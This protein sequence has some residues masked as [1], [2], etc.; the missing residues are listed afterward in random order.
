MRLAALTGG[1][2][3]VV[4]SAQ[5]GAQKIVNLP[6]TDR[7]APGGTYLIGLALALIELAHHTAPT[8]RE[9]WLN[10][11]VMVACGFAASA[12]LA[13]W[14]AAVDA[15]SPDDRTFGALADTWR[16]V[17]GSLAAFAVSETLDNSLGAWVRGR[18]PE[19]TRVVGTNLV[20]APLDSLVF[21]GI[22]FGLDDLNLVEGQFYGKMLATVLIGLPL[23]YALRRLR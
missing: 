18:V 9:G 19:W 3:G 1:Y 21:I 2:V 17:A 15:M 12:I 14:I 11:Q 6:F 7:R 8:R 5:I 22:A 10:A 16:I 23:V 13:A 20:S 4:C